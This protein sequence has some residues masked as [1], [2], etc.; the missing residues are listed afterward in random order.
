MHPRVLGAARA[1]AKYLPYLSIGAIAFAASPAS[2]AI[3]AAIPGLAPVV[4]AIQNGSIGIG[5]G[6]AVGGVAL[7][8]LMFHHDQRGDWT[9]T[10]QGLGLSACGGA[11][12]SN[13]LAIA[14]LGGAGA[15]VIH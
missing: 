12:A 14:T 10:V 7:K 6:G 2:A 15:L 5:V 8:S 11:V 9:H 1:A 4:T 13:A 3:G